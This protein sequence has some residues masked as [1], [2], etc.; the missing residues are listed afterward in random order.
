MG[1]TSP[2]HKMAIIH[3]CRHLKLERNITQIAKRPNYKFKNKQF[4]F[5]K[6][7]LSPNWAIAKELIFRVYFN[8][9][10]GILDS[11]DYQYL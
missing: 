11:T 6:Y 7:I 5:Q 9:L 2:V 8:M 1:T 3:E 10:H 4:Y